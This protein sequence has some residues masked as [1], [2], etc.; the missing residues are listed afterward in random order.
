VR[1]FTPVSPEEADQLER[2][3]PLDGPLYWT[4]RPV[5][6]EATEGATWMVLTIPY[7]ELPEAVEKPGLDTGSGIAARALSKVH[8]ET[9]RSGRLLKGPSIGPLQRCISWEAARARFVVTGDL[10]Q[11]PA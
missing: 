6:E 10:P 8:S 11:L 7:Q 5:P 1:L 3:V 4:D 9:G 2:G